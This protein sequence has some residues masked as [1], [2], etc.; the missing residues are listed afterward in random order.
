MSA[1]RPTTIRW[2]PPSCTASTVQS[3]HTAQSCS[4]GLPNGDEDH[5]PTSNFSPPGRPNAA[6]TC[7]CSSV[8]T[9]TENRPVASIRGHDRDVRIT[10]NSTNGGFRLNEENDWQ[11]NPTGSPSSV[12]TMVTPV[13]NSP[14]ALRIDISSNV[15]NAAGRVPRIS[16]GRTLLAAP[17]ISIFANNRWNAGG[18][19]ESTDPP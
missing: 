2:S 16:I 18:P 11:A 1:T 10:V 17:T 4:T 13:A 3:I 9:F 15:S 7:S 12:A 14:S 19:S 6:D 8:S 5:S